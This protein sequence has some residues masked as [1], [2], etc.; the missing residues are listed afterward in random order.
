MSG[1]KRRPLSRRATEKE[2]RAIAAESAAMAVDAGA[3]ASLSSC[4]VPEGDLYASLP[5]EER[6]LLRKVDFSVLQLFFAS[7]FCRKSNLQKVTIIKCTCF[8]FALMVLLVY[9]KNV[10]FNRQ[11]TIRFL[12]SIYLDY[13]DDISVLAFS[14]QNVLL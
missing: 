2:A 6:D 13:D 4:T 8:L 5:D 10:E 12:Y 3:A 1:K 7:T 11:I 9:F 14:H